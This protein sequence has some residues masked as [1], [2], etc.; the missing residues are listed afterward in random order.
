MTKIA[1]LLAFELLPER[2]TW[3]LLQKLFEAMTGKSF[4]KRNF[5]KKKQE[6]P[7]IVQLEEMQD[8]VAQHPARLFHYDRV[9]FDHIRAENLGN[10]F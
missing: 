10:L 6:M 9:I 5:R 8:E 3:T 4:E 2:F 1:H 7:F